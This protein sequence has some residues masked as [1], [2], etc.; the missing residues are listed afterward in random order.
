MPATAKCHAVLFTEQIANINTDS[1]Q[2]IFF[3]S[4]KLSINLVGKSDS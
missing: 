1:I 4:Y 3:K 2:I